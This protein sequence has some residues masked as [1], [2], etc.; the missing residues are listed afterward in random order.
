MKIPEIDLCLIAPE[1][2]IAGFGLLVLLVDVF[3][4]QRE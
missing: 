2:I 4:T 1:M 3:Y